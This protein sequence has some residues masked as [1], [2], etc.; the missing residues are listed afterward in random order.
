MMPIMQ[1]IPFPIGAFPIMRPPT[2]ETLD[3]KNK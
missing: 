2:Q 1:P 3:N